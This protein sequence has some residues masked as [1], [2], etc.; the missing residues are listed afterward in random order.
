MMLFRAGAQPGLLPAT[1]SSAV[2][3][4]F[5]GQSSVRGARPLDVLL[6]DGE[7]RQTLAAMRVYARAGLEVGSIACGPNASWAPS[8]KSRWG[9]MGATVPDFDS[10]PG[11]F[12]DGVLGLLDAHPAHMLLPAHDGSIQALRPRRAEVERR[13]AL[14]LASEAAL[15][16]AVS[17]ERTLALATQLGIAVPRSVLVNDVAELRAAMHE[18]GFPAV[19]KPIESWVERNGRGVRL[20]PNVVLTAEE[21]QQTMEHVIEEGG[22]ALLQQWVPG[23]RE[24][25]SLFYARGQFWARM[26]QMSYREWP[27]LGGAS[28]LCETIPLLP[29]ITSDAERL[30]RAIDL[31][32]C[33]M[34]EFRRDRDGCPVLMEV[35][36]RMGGSVS[37]AIAVGV[38]FPGMTYDWKLDRP[39]A[40]VTTYQVGKRLRWLA[41]DVWNLK[42]VFDNQ[43]HPD[44]PPRLNALATFVLDCLRPA[45]KLDGIEFDDLRP[46]LAEMNKIVLQPGVSRLRSLLSSSHS[47][48]RKGKSD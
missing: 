36:P 20:S 48:S 17:K 43:G 16:I 46:A 30:V 40:E 39:L 47:S 44:L 33:S 29:D 6:L 37:L 35:N 32:G 8:L 22:R 13:T 5:E 34:V 23:R 42:C 1:S 4:T 28:V 9:S 7:N 10:D 31:E 25:V 12:V 26:A 27:V 41:G 24:A 11:R 38:N 18:V 19:I 45:N 3:L 2:G 15:S 14:A 21:A